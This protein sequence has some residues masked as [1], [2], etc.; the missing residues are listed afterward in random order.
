M[1]GGF[2]CQELLKWE[3]P[4]AQSPEIK[5]ESLLRILETS[6]TACLAPLI[7]G[8]ASAVGQLEQGQYIAALETTLTAGAVTLILIGTVNLGSQVGSVGVLTH[9]R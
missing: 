2:L 1:T 5:G 7:S 6:K 9:L 4:T 8:G 3:I